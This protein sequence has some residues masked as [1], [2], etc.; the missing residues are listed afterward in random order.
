M[1]ASES[2]DLER[3]PISRQRPALCRPLS[4]CYGCGM[5]RLESQQRNRRPTYAMVEA[6]ADAVAKV[7]AAPDPPR[8]YCEQVARAAIAA[9]LT[10]T[11]PC[12]AYQPEVD[13][14]IDAILDAHPETGERS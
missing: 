14:K 8:W 7:L 13:A 3:D 12:P 1:P 11:K 9:A 4:F 5:P 6:G 10:V 2:A